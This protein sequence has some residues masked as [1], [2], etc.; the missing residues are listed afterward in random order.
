MVD[1]KSAMTA[2]FMVLYRVR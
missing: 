2:G 1:G